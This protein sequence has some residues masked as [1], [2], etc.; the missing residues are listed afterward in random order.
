MLRKL[1]L[2]EWIINDASYEK[3]EGLYQII[4]Y[5]DYNCGLKMLIDNDS[6]YE[7]FIS[8]LKE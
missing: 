1:K 8:N 3:L 6:E 2:I 7:D 5:K 4:M